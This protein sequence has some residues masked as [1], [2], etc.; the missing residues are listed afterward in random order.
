M[1]QTKNTRKAIIITLVTSLILLIAITVAYFAISVSNNNNEKINATSSTISIVYTDC[2]SSK[3]SDCAN[4]TKNLALGESFEKTFKVR[5]TG[6]VPT[7]YKIIFKELTNTFQ[8]GDLVYTIKDL[9]DTVLQSERPVPYAPS[10]TTN[11]NALLDTI[12]AGATK[13][14]KIVVKL[15]ETT[16][17]QTV[18]M[19]ATYAIKL[20]ITTQNG[21]TDRLYNLVADADPNSIDVITKTSPTGATCTNTLA[22]DGTAD[23]NLRYVG[24][25]PCNYVSFN[26][27][28]AGWRII[29]I[30]N[31]I[32]DGTGK[33]ETRIKLIRKDSIGSYSWDTSASNVNSGYGVN[34]WSQ[35]DLMRELNGDYL[36]NTLTENTTWYN[37]QNNQI[38]A[39]FDITKRLGDYSQVL[40]GNTKWY[41]GGLNT[42]SALA[43]DYYVAERGTTVYNGRPTEWI[44]KIAL[45]YPSDY[46]YAVGGGVRND[47]LDLTLY[48]Y[49]NNTGCY[50]NDYLYLSS[51]QWFLTPRSDNAQ[52]VFRLCD[53][54]VDDLVGTHYYGVGVPYPTYPAFYL[55]SSVK[56]TGGD[57]SLENP[58]TLG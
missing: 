46:G 44:G 40:I 21:G 43:L 30:M 23:N 4:M 10:Q 17:D 55:K 25:D 7:D 1:K 11:V 31:N 42:N 13:E 6:T 47:C 12:A 3:Q 39:S 36:D 51:F 45:S 8:N 35:A 58:Y 56:I 2:A 37:G 32:D 9:N 22:Y 27:E 33:K 20:G 5:N 29:G 24:A 34:D 15:K 57:V 50:L 41:L 54:K 53:G 48:N 52:N 16:G 38:T 14:F 18:N 49:N 26:E 28:T 19:N